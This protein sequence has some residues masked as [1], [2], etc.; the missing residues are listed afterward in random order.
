MPE[1]FPRLFCWLSAVSLLLM[2]TGVSADA[3]SSRLEK[4][5]RGATL[6]VVVAF[7]E[8]DPLSYEKP[9]PLELLPFALRDATHVPIGTAFRLGRNEYVTAAHVISA[10]VGGQFGP[11]QLRDAQGRIYA[12]DQILKYSFQEDFAV[13]SLKDPPRSPILD[14][15]PEP[16]PSSTVFAVG[17]ALGEGIIVR[18][19]VYTS[20][21][22]EQQDGK[23]N[24]LRFSAAASPGNS[25][26][27]LLNHKGQVIGVVVAKSP[28]ENLNYALPVSRV[29][30]ARE[31]IARVVMRTPFGVPFAPDTIV[32]NVDENFDLP[33][34][35]DE[36]AATIQKIGK[37]TF[38]RGYAELQAAYPRKY[39]P[40]GDNSAE[41][42][43]ST[44]IATDPRL[45]V[46][47]NTKWEA[48]EPDAIEH[49]DLGGGS[50]M[51][52][53]QI[54]ETGLVGI[55]LGDP[56]TLADLV[57]DSRKFMDLFLKGTPITRLVG[58]EAV[59]ITSLGAAQEE[60][61]FTDSYGRKWLLRTWD[62]PFMDA[63]IVSA[64][65]PVPQGFIVVS[66]LAQSALTYP[67]TE[68]I[69]MAANLVYVTY[70]G[71]LPEWRQYLALSSM[72]PAVFADIHLDPDVSGK[73]SYGSKRFDFMAGNDLLN[74][75]DRSIIDLYFAYFPDHGKI[76][77][78][79]AGLR[80]REDRQ[81]KVMVEVL[82]HARPPDGLPRRFQDEWDD[83]RMRRTPYN[84]I[85]RLDGMVTSTGTTVTHL[86]TSSRIPIPQDA[87]IIY[88]ASYL[89]ELGFSA[90]ELQTLSRLMLGDLRV[91]E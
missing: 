24:W 18:D 30:D 1:I 71:T 13:V 56:A 45:I 27:P 78:D 40:L 69:K 82:R 14:T 4:K 20:A 16:T 41:L 90:A 72:Q 85:P 37:R 29:L 9:L 46:R 25:G 49:I 10:S 36:F 67:M 62:L 80:I 23:W 44:V 63:R 89:A 34:S 48:L 61:V 65:L 21:T 26:G 86:A 57:G 74:I 53:G 38:D 88:Q 51:T 52:V 68:L 54:A 75:Q 64:A 39:F 3:L 17:N 59:R 12:I 32:L 79:V 28:N 66:R 5:V 22:P 81:E 77:W 2:A 87:T 42:L 60:S 43:N 33:L 50:S 31:G 83:L 6:E 15:G 55:R 84:G 91:S 76:V 73:L 47:K 8:S 7:P 35:F 70:S 58:P 19:G 11:P